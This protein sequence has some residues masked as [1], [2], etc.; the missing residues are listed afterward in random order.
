MP[1]AE[2]EANAVLYLKKGSEK[3]I[4]SGHLWVYSNEI[5]ADRKPLKGLIPGDS[6]DIFSHGGRWL[7]NG[8]VNPNSLICARIASHD[9]S[10]PLSRSLLVHRL[11]VALGLRQR[12]YEHNCYRLAYGEGD[13]LPGL[14]IDRYG[15][16]YVVQLNTAGME[17]LR[18][19]VLSAMDKVLRPDGV[20][21]R[22]DSE[23]RSME[24][25]DSYVD[26]WGEV[27]KEVELVEN[28]T[29]FLVPLRQGQ[30]TGWYFDHRDNRALLLRLASGRRVLDVCSYIGAWGIQAANHGASHVHCV[31]A[32]DLALAYVRRN[33][34]LNRVDSIQTLHGDA[35]DIL[36]ALRSERIRF[37]IVVLD[38][39]AF[40]KRKKDRRVGEDAY[41]RLNQAALQVIEK[42]GVLVSCSCS[43]HLS[44]ERLLEITNRAARHV[45]RHL[46]L[47]ATSG[48]GMDHPVHPA[49]PET[50]YLKCLMFRVLP[51]M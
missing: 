48:Q 30:K 34:E 2:A 17:R 14:I 23:F 9:R 37:D 25:L 15:A 27:P 43:H 22:C 12:L 44:T 20:L 18:E 45:D 8:Y 6:V 7:G 21:L 3:R 11:K 31:D 4:A 33:A 39:P 19:D 5:D 46:Q 26:A 32:S 40:I 10:H 41:R 24:G 29:R 47:L 35:F 51:R 28:D 13:G 36:K 42:D 38:P 49:M 16:H 1:Q 50:R